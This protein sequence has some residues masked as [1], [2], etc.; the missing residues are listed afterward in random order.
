M[1]KIT[2]YTDG[3][4]R[5][6]PGIGGYGIVL[7][8]TPYRKEIFGAYKLTTNNRMELLAVIIALEALKF[9]NSDVTLYSDSRYVVDAIEKKW[10]NSWE[11]KNFKKV[12]N[13][14]LWER[15]L[16]VFRR[17]SVKFVWVKGHSENIENQRCDTLAN[18]AM[19]KGEFL[20]DEGYLENLKSEI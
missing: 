2:I 8:S 12:K 10:L 7:L 3:A 1:R 11:N 19:D 20:I 16:K 15:F 5:G 6:N 13:V 9:D 18:L 4:S 14:D 17:H